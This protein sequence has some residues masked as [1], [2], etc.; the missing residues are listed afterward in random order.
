MLKQAVYTIEKNINLADGIY[1]M[2]LL[3][4]H[5]FTKP[6]QFANIKIDGLY[7]RRPISVC[8]FDEKGFTLIYKTVGVGTDKLSTMQKGERLDIITGLGNGYDTSK[9]GDS[10]ILIAGGSGVPPMYKLAKT[11]TAEGKRVKCVLGFNKKSDVYLEDELKALGAGVAITTVDG[12]YGKKGFVTDALMESEYSFFYTC[13]PLPMYN[14]I[15]KV[16]KTKGQYSF[17]ERMGCGF[18]ACMGCSMKTASGNKRI[19]KDGPV[20]DCDDIIWEDGK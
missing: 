6:G 3:G 9:S 2:A 16:A 10:P 7:L 20:F 13:G 14:A 18:G 19:C 11:L 8:D 1:L 17:E 5:G 15:R 12:S 4:E